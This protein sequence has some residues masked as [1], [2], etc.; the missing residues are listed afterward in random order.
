MFLSKYGEARHIYIPIIKR[1]VVDFAVSADW[2][3]AAGDVKISK[4]GGAA[5]N[6]TNL[7]TA[8]TMGNTAMWDFSLTATEMQA[9]QIKVTVADAATKAVED[10]MFV[11]ETYGNASAQH[12]FDLDTATPGVN[13]TQWLGTAAA[14][15]TVAG[16]PEVDVT[17]FNGTAGTFAAGRPEVNTSHVAGTA[18]TAGDI[19]ADTND[20]QSRLP[21]ALVGGRMDSS[22][23]AYQT[24]MAP[25]QP[26]VAGRTL[27]VTLTG[28]A[29]LDFDNTAGTLAKGTDI[30]GFNDLDAAGVR[31]AVGLAAANLDTQLSGIQS[32]TDNIQTRLPAA[33]VGG[34]MDSDMQAAAAGVITSTVAPNLDAAVST[35]AT[36]A[37]VNAEVLDVLNVD[38]FAESAAVPA[39][40]STL[41]DKI[42]WLFTLARN[43]IT[44]TSTTQTLR[45][46]ADTADVSTST[47]SDDG[48]T[49]TRGEWV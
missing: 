19:I 40:T 4:D 38:T 35:R 48:T 26:T 27:D 21:A 22:V 33:L 31:G 12:A 11:I 5:A 34:R 28:E 49:H 43:K 25:L 20:I 30:T 46:D 9:A 32:D 8:I 39:A 6:V 13:V 44:Q 17:H 10:T 1:A 36:P 37:Q 24:G 3:P 29:G 41:V 2:T 45:N 23:G 42:R 47:H 15:P 7:P 16:V 18:Q 14:T